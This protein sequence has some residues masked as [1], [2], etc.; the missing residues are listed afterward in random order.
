MPVQ[1]GVPPLPQNPPRA[2]QLAA[3]HAPATQFPLQHCVGLA[4]PL[5]FAEQALVQ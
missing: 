2:T 3:A 1:H 4:Q 5:P